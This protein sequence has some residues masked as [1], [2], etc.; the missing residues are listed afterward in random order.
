MESDT[1]QDHPHKRLWGL[2]AAIY[3]A[4]GGGF[5]GNQFAHGPKSAYIDSRVP[6]RGRQ[7]KVV[8]LLQKALVEEAAKQG[9]DPDRLPLMPNLPELHPERG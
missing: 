6:R 7:L 2:Q 1:S 8:Y 3:T 5:I 4:A 9:L